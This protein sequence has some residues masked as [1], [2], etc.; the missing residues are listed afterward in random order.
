MALFNERG[1]DLVT[2]DEITQKAGVAKGTF[3]TYFATKS[4][5]IVEEFWDIDAYYELYSSKNLPNYTT[6]R[7]KLLAFTRAQMRYVRDVVGNQKSENPVRESGGP[8]RIGE[9]D[10]DERTPMV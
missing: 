5:I 9:D 8:D 4:D 10:H 1:F 7:E 2:V 6:S 3:Y